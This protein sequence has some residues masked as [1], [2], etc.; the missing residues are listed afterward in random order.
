VA[1]KFLSLFRPISR[2]LPEVAPPEKRPSFKA[3]LA[4]TAVAL[5]IYL[6]MCNTPLYGA[7]TGGADP[8]Y[9]MRIIFASRRGTLMELGIGPIV[10]AGIV[11]Q[12]LAASRMIECDFTNPEDRALFTA[13]SKF[14]SI[15]LTGVN[16]L[17]YIMGGVY[18]GL[19]F[20]EAALIF[21]QL[22]MAGIILILLDE[23][24]QK[25][26]G[27]GSGIS[28]F[29][30]AGVAVNIFWDSLNPMPVGDK[31]SHGALIATVQCIM[32]GDWESLYDRGGYPTLLGFVATLVAFLV[33]I[34]MQTTRV[35]IPISYARFRGF[36]GRYPIS[37]LYVSNIPVIFA[38]ALFANVY[39]ISQLLW[40]H[41]KDQDIFWLKLLG[42]YG[43]DPETG[44][45]RPT[46]GLVY[47]MVAPRGIGDVVEDPVRAAVYLFIMVLSCAI[48]AR[49]WLEVGGLDPATVARQIVD[50]GLQVPG[51]R[52]SYQAVKR[53]LERYIPTTTIL[54]G[55][56][57][58]L[59]AA[60]ADF[61]GTFGTGTGILLSVGIIYQ[62]Y[63]VL[64][65]ER[66][67]EMYPALAK[68]LGTR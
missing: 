49:L 52:R 20:R 51:F 17:A 30:L 21:A 10:T 23:M 63:Q 66:L 41:F 4:W 55:I 13:A 15:V 12:L 26:W 32:N 64:A 61:F 3:R 2:F 7:P 65:R 60:V 40:N 24:I 31:L 29:I 38:S 45:I 57:V 6:I 5:V 22:L 18:G 43:Q 39:F 50:A 67:E 19:G 28:L 58:G 44:R 27:L 9:Y 56:L 14:F 54:G 8:F 46:G 16:A 68:L 53:L 37:L 62:Y 33:C 59:L 35:E 1:G 48:F 25:G 34:Y 42:T 47:Y 36:R 11:L